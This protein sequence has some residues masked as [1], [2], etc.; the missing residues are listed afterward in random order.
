MVLFE[1]RRKDRFAANRPRGKDAMWI[2]RHW[3]MLLAVLATLPSL[4]CGLV[5]VFDWGSRIDFAVTK[6]RDIGGIGVVIELFLIAAMA[7]ISSTACWGYL[8]YVGPSKE[9]IHNHQRQSGFT[10][11]CHCD[12][13]LR[14]GSG[15]NG[16]SQELWENIFYLAL[17]SKHVTMTQAPGALRIPTVFDC[18]RTLILAIE[19]SNTSWVLAAQIPGLPGVQAKRSI[20]PT[21]EALMAAIDGYR[22]RA[23]KAGR[24]VDRVDAVY[25]AGWSGFWLVRAEG[26]Q[27]IGHEKVIP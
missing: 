8:D 2:K 16:L 5:W 1:R 24:N 26:T 12:R 11:P 20:E 3:P 10:E 27:E 19:L 25:Q 4:W 15:E 21:P 22:V 6:V 23:E 7:D 14:V 9:S 13:R 18:E 17:Q